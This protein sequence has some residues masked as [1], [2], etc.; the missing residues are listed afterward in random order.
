MKSLSRDFEGGEIEKESVLVQTFKLLQKRNEKVENVLTRL[1]FFER[2]VRVLKKV[3]E[4]RMEKETMEEEKE[5][6]ED[7]DN[8]KDK[9][10]DQEGNA[11]EEA[12]QKDGDEDSSATNSN[13]PSHICKTGHKYALRQREAKNDCKET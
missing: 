8:E 6:E 4:M 10:D 3:T 1:L 12:E 13:G 5:N 2:K 11:S 7:A 9:E